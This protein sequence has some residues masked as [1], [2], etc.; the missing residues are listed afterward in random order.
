MPLEWDKKKAATNLKKHGVSF[1][2]AATVLQNLRTAEFPDFKHSAFEE[3]WI[4][5]GH[6]NAG[7]LLVVCYTEPHG[8]IRIISARNATK[9]EIKI[10]E[11]RRPK[12]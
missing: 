3:R 5:I 6:S 2:E 12:N 1:D 8:A 10:Y 7:R 9:Q 11:E 4:A